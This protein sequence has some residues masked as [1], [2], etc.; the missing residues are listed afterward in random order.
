MNHLY[1]G[2][3]LDVLRKYVKD[4]SIDLCYIDPPF[5][6]K[7][8]YNQI[9]NNVGK[10]DLAQAQAFIDTWEWND[11][12]IKGFS[13]IIENYHGSFTSQTINLILGLEKVLGMGSL[14]AYLVSIT[15]RVVEI[16]RVLK[17]T[18][19]F[20]LHCDPTSS[21]YIKLILDSV[22]CAM[23]GNFLNEIIWCYRGGGSPK[24]DF[25]RRHDIIFRYSKGK[26][27]IFNADF[28]RIPYQAEGFNR[29]DDAMWG[30]HKGTNKVY[31]PNPLGKVPEDWW[32][33]NPLNS[34]DPERLGYPTQ[35]PE[36]LLERIIQAS[37]NPGD[38]VLDPFCGSGTTLAVAQKL[39]RNWIGIDMNPDA[40]E[41]T[42][43]RL[44][45]PLQLR[46]A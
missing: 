27:Y 39:G 33:L 3:N 35:K 10:E 31:K 43:R 13:E 24:K 26:E 32:L 17:P 15:L 42:R 4:E 14:L 46:L 28:I 8:N 2:D 11:L 1:Y 45:E 5:N 18:G 16:H 41:L 7:R 6:S 22:F 21:H 36:A 34:N 29:K 37:S 12:A 25:G 38:V 44:D 40:I 20:Y 9:Y 19:S 23:G 30:K